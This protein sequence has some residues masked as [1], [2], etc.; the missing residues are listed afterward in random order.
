MYAESTVVKSKRVDVRLV[1]KDKK[2]VLLMEMTR[3]WI[4]NR[5]KKETE[6]TT[7]YAPLRWQ[8][9]ERYKRFLT[10]RAVLFSLQIQIQVS[11]KQDGLQHS[12]ALA[13]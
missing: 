8:M 3:P 13:V 9:K 2:E 7:K 10:P 4:G 12:L 11:T 6:K 1:D 5:G